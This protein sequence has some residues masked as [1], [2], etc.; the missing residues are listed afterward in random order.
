MFKFL[1][2]VYIFEKR[3][4]QLKMVK[5]CKPKVLIVED[6]CGLRTNLGDFLELYHFDVEIASNGTDA[7]TLLNQ[8]APDII[9]S[10]LIMPGM[11]GKT[12]LRAIQA[13]EA[14]RLIPFIYMTG[15]TDLQDKLY[16]LQNGAI[17]YLIKPFMLEELLYK[18]NN[19][20][21]L[22]NQFSSVQ[23]EAQSGEPIT[24]GFKK[25]FEEALTNSYHNVSLSLEDIAD[26]VNMSA[27]AL[28]RKI[29]R[30]Y[31]SNFS[32]VVKEYR[33]QKARLLLVKSDRPIDEVARMCG[34][35]SASYFSRIFKETSR[36]S[37]V[38]YRLQQLGKG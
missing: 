23:P 27:S 13:N 20:I 10:D 36:L 18:I 34:F 16:G 3:L 15:K 35:S 17:D 22:R 4:W 28:Q 11:D 31:Q 9:V 37:P 21:Q 30:Y 1:L 12:F 26:K 19:I 6:D 33:L 29:S 14:F 25:Q 8:Q 24:F 5:D 32:S 2:T 38:Q 7:L